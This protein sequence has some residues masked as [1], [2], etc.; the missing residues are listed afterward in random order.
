M[1]TAAVTARGKLLLL[2]APYTLF[3]DPEVGGWEGAKLG[4][5]DIVGDSV[6][7]KLQVVLPISHERL[8][9][10]DIVEPSASNATSTLKN[11]S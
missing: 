11:A 3:D 2:L 8:D 7:Y 5:N 6:L 10:V 1:L 4:A 9:S